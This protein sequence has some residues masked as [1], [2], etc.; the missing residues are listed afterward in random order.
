[1]KLIGKFR[2]DQAVNACKARSSKVPLP[3]NRQAN[4]DTYAAFKE[5]GV[6]EAA[7]DGTDNLIE[8][9]WVEQST[10]ELIKWFN[11]PSSGYDGVT[12][13][14]DYLWY[15]GKFPGKWDDLEGWQS[16]NVICEKDPA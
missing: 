7:L 9:D 15:W 13:R 2:L 11:W 1:M 10:G 8:G 3:K 6:S 16:T 12:H 5:L 4:H 14:Q